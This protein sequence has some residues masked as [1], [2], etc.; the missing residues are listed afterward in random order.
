[1][2]GIRLG[3]ALSQAVGLL[4]TCTPTAPIAS[5]K[6]FSNR[7]DLSRTT[8]RWEALFDVLHSP[9]HNW[10]SLS[11]KS[12][13]PLTRLIHAQIDHGPAPAEADPP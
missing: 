10:I 7:V 2:K 9:K 8:S 1:M 5:V 6:L 4:E 13:K 3:H 12:A 11:F